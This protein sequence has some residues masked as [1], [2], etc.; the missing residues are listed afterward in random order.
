VRSTRRVSNSRL[1]GRSHP[2]LLTQESW[3][4]NRFATERMPKV[5]T[6][7][8]ARAVPAFGLT[9]SNSGSPPGDAQGDPWP[10][11]ETVQLVFR[12]L[13]MRVHECSVWRTQDHR[14]GTPPPRSRPIRN[15]ARLRHRRVADLPSWRQLTARV[16]GR[17][18]RRG[19]PIEVRHANSS[20]TQI[21]VGSPVMPSN[22]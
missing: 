17:C 2:L 13:L 14:I 5:S 7:R 15:Q 16:C 21:G 3:P 12:L 22:R 10:D 8:W 9:L 4:R 11:V 18:E 20:S 19:S 6:W 1:P